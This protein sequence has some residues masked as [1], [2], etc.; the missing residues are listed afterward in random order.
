[1]SFA[2][3][4]ATLPQIADSRIA[5]T[6]TNQAINAFT[7]LG[8]PY[9]KEYIANYRGVKARRDDGKKTG[10]E[11]TSLAQRDPRERS[12]LKKVDRELGLIEYSNFTG[13][14]PL[15]S[16]CS[17]RRQMADFDKHVIDYAEMV[18]QFG[19][20][21]VWSVVWPLAPLFALINNWLELRT[22]A[23][24]IATHVRRPIAERVESIGPWLNTMVCTTS[25][26]YASLSA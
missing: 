1:M 16:R 19:Y 17:S 22:D 20:I 26:K 24:K 4:L 23:A 7:E 3:P 11:P 15:L 18:T 25:V 14:F 21:T 2:S 12:L 13:Q 8:L 9:I 5:D 6:V 10:V